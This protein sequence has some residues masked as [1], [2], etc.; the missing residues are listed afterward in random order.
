MDVLEIWHERIDSESL[1]QSMQS[2]KWKKIT[3]KQIARVV[4]EMISQN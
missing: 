2:G 1:I 4:L 3:Q